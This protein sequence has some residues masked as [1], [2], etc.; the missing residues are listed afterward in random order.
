LDQR[1]RPD[2]V[3][4]SAANNASS[5]GSARRDSNRPAGNLGALVMMV[6]L[7]VG[8]VLAVW[9]PW[10]T[11]HGYRIS[12]LASATVALDGSLPSVGGAMRGWVALAMLC[13]LAQ[14]AALAMVTR[15]RWLVRACV[16][17]VSIAMVG[18]LAV[19]QLSDFSPTPVAFIATG[20]LVISMLI[21]FIHCAHSP[22]LRAIGS[23]LGVTLVLSTAT[24]VVL[25]IRHAKP[26]ANTASSA[27][28]RFVTAASESDGLD[29]MLLL[30]PSERERGVS[31]AQQ[32]DAF[33]RPL[34]VI[35]SAFDLSGSTDLTVVSE[36]RNGTA[37]I[38]N[39]APSS[40]G[41]GVLIGLAGGIPI[42]TVQ[43]GGHWY[44]SLS[45]TLDSLGS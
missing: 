3:G 19:T 41:A 1:V 44:V 27:A 31:L 13:L 5:N 8:I 40:G 14:L 9:G 17:V 43:Q 25:D 23:V 12:Q 28:L 24:R 29:A 45:A 4:S 2:L 36:E 16:V 37:T 33:S 39:L 10:L 15:K 7:G 32:I 18:A 38:V 42:A 35:S 20:L 26:S 30:A 6:L 34:S 22:L 11:V 21:T